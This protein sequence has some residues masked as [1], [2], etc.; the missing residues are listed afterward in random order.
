[1]KS[2][3]WKT[4]REHFYN[5]PIRIKNSAT[6]WNKNKLININATSYFLTFSSIHVIIHLEFIQVGE[7]MQFDPKN[8]S[9]YNSPFQHVY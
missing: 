1:M 8:V 3:Q 2:F 6:F 7:F 9:H 4:L 5:W